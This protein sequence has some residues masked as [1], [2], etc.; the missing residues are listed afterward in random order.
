MKPVSHAKASLLC[1]VAFPVCLMAA[2]ER[3]PKLV[4]VISVDQMRGDVFD[5]FGDLFTG[6]LR[7]LSEEGVHFTQAHHEHAIT[8]TGPA[9]FV[10][11]TGHHPGRGG[12]IGNSWYDRNAGEY[13]YCVGDD[14][15]RTIRSRHRGVSYRNVGASALGDWMKEKYPASKV[16]AISVKDRAAVLLGGKEADGVFW[17]E[18][19]T[20]RFV[21]SDY[22]MKR[23]PR[24]MD[25]FNRRKPLNRYFGAVW[26]RYLGD[27]SEYDKRCRPDEFPGEDRSPSVQDRTF[28]HIMPE[29]SVVWRPKYGDLWHFPYLDEVLL[30]L[31]ELITEKEL[32][33]RDDSPDLLNIGLSMADAVG[34]RY[35]PFS[36]EVMD[37]F[38]LMDQYLMVF[39]TYLDERIGLE[40]VLIAF[41]SDHGAG[42]LPE[43]S[44]QLG[45]GGGRYGKE[46][47]KLLSRANSALSDVFGKAKYIE[48]VAAGA[49]YYDRAVMASKGLSHSDIDGVL[50]PLLSEVEWIDQ[51]FSRSLVESPNELSPIQRRYGN[52]FHADNSGDLFYVPTQYWIGKHPYG[53]SHG[54]PYE[55][56]SHVPMIFA[57]SGLEAANVGKRVETVDFAPTIATL[58]GL[59]IPLGIDG[60]SVAK[61][62]R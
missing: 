59:N 29:K 39:F 52:N 30:D 24:W 48:A 3:N 2:P 26:N 23:Y 15:A 45:L 16:Y 37:M 25:D 36:H 21:T 27:A 6:G 57:G 7:Y 51:V 12:V 22:Y 56:D 35:G 28:P 58:L 8:A 54:T 42:Y 43:Y 60:K 34:H 55:W 32:L 5:R 10:L 13:V 44:Q 41:T 62:F 9:H 1:L 38:L 53:A 4:V 49:L 11:A 50:T 40:N 33:G 31:A 17:L 47:R 61:E 46:I 14:E 20:G 18:T 19:R